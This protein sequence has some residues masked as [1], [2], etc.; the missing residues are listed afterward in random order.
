MCGRQ[1]L[2]TRNS[3]DAPLRRIRAGTCCCR[4]R[5]AERIPEKPDIVVMAHLDEIALLVV[6]V[7]GDGRLV[8]TNLGGAFP[9]K[10]G[11][12]PV[13]IL[14]AEKALTGILSFGSIHTND[15]ASVAA[16]ARERALTWADTR[17]FTGLSADALTGLGVR[18]GTP[19]CSASVPA[20]RDADGG[21]SRHALSG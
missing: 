7:E 21:L 16:Q 2:P 5:G 6:R 18:A 17:I 3:W 14:A 11:E 13:Q 8:V 9:W 10:W 1:L 19:G 4:C 15:P 20:R 12:G